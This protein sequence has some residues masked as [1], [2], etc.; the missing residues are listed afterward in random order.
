MKSQSSKTFFAV[1]ISLMLILTNPM[2][3]AASPVL[4]RSAQEEGNSVEDAFAYLQSQMNPDGG[5]VW[6]DENSAVAPTIKAVQALAAN[7]LTQDALLSAEGNRPIDFLASAGEAWVNQEEIENPAFSVARAGQ[8]LA[9][10][11]AA[12]EDPHNFGADSIDLVYQVQA[13][14]DPSTGA[15]GSAAPE[16]VIDQVWA[17]IGLAANNASIPAEAADWLAA[18][19]LEDG[20]WDDGYGSYLDTTPLGILALAS[21]GQHTADSPDIASA[22]DFI[23]ASQQP[24]GGWQTEWDT[25]TNA[26]TT[27]VILQAIYAIGQTPTA[28][29][30]QTEEGNPATALAVL[31]KEDGSIGGDFANAYSTADALI[32]LAGQS[33]TSLGDLS[34]ADNAFDFL[35]SAQD[36]SGGWESVGQTL[37]VILA[38]EAAGWQPRTVQTEGVSPVDYVAANLDPYL[39]AGPD[40]IGKAIMGVVASDEDPFNFNGVDLTEQLLGTYDDAAQ[41]FGD[42]E[43]TWHQA[44]AILGL[45]A[46]DAEIP[47]GAASSLA[48]LQQEDGGWEYTPGFGAWPDNTALAMQALL[49]AGYD[50]SDPVMSEALAYLQSTQTADGGWGDSS[51]T[52]YA[53]MALNALGESEEDWGTD[54]GMTPLTSLMTYQKANGSFVYNR[55]FTDD[56]VMSTAS[57]LLALFGEDYLVQPGGPEAANQAA[58]IID[59]GEEE[60]QSACVEFT[61]E[62]ISGLDLLD[63]SGF[64]YD[65]PDGF[66]S[67]ILGLTNPEGETN[68]W[69]YWAWDGREW[70]FKETGASGSEVLPGAIEAWHF[71]SWEQFPSL[72]PDVIPEMTAICEQANLKDYNAQPNLGY[73]DLY[74]AVSTQPAPSEPTAA[75]TAAE[76]AQPAAA[77]ATAAATST[78]G[79]T[80]AENESKILSI[81]PLLVIGILGV[82]LVVVIVL[83]V[84]GKKE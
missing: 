58:I 69:S 83:I 10:L 71:T 66:V 12:N 60:P 65:A 27:A 76:A 53:L 37:D 6:M 2:T 29:N 64:D 41:A 38:L 51:T 79:P 62:S 16:N 18:A 8:L 46:A 1:L 78:S 32:G 70:V 84:T 30:W 77:T 48:G 24:S 56:S 14:Y 75:P 5:V 47:E 43:N 72:P 11:A 13:Q 44:L 52:A 28:E 73:F 4:M 50:P 25:T 3:A 33:I 20:S 19:Q 22:M 57:A 74:P 45:S 80:A 17:M 68:Y 26:D 21:S 36:A 31:Q 39:E 55:E 54:A 23:A 61:D 35:F 42:P 15:Y 59:P 67:A 63:A 34:Q 49:A 81:L 9:A 82:G 40:A 7:G